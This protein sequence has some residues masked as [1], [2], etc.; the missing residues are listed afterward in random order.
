MSVE[1]YGTLYLMPVWLGDAGGVEQLPP[2]NIGLAQ[3]IT[4]Y[5]SEHEKTARHMLRRMVP[6][7][8]LTR[9][10]MH[11]LDKDTTANEVSDLVALLK[12]GRDAAIVSEGGM[13]GIADPG[14]RLVQAAHTAGVRVMPLI[15]PSSL[16]L[17]LAASGLNGQQFTFHGYLPI[18]PNERKPA[19]KRLELDAQR[20][21][22]A[23]L[24]IETPYR[25]DGLFADLLAT[26]SPGTVLTI[27]I[28]LTQPG[29][30]VRT[31]DIAQWKK[32]KPELGKRPAVFILGAW[33][34]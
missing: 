4:L 34:R 12:N 13:P 23:Q 21:G 24:L 7:I 14:A 15:G 5:F 25:N 6:D 29:G 2:E 11:R 1:G 17:A 30:S 27:A 32:E 33:P 8:D 16:F 9:L 3:R 31:C 20:T 10:E 22:G 26:C 18:K 19:I 28:D